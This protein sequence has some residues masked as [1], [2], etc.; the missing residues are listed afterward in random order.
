MFDAHLRPAALL[1]AVGYGAGAVLE[2]VHDQ[3]STFAGV[4]DYLIEAGFVVGLAATVVVLVGLVRGQRSTGSRLT[5][6]LA[7]AGN[8]ATLVAAGGTLLLGREVL[9]SLFFAG[10]LATILGYLS[11]AVL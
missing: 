1:A 5:L 10:V 6:G 9:D 2:L 4:T 11:S 7:A 8:A 3:P